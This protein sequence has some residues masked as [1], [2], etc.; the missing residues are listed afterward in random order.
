MWALKHSHKR[1]DQPHQML[2]KELRHGR[3]RRKRGNYC[4]NRGCIPNRVSI[5]SRTTVVEKR[6][7]IGDMEVDL[8]PGKDHQPGLMVITDRSTLRTSL[9]KIK[10]KA[11]RYIASSIIRKLKP[12]ESWIKTLTYDNY[13]AFAAHATVN[14]K[15][16]TKS[17]FTHPYTSEEKGTVENRIGVLRK[18][19]PKKTDFTLIT[20]RRVSQVEKM[21]NERPVRKFQYQ[22]PNAIFLQKSKVALIT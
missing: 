8:M 10:T 21:I 13:L 11:S 1:E 6:S 12:C 19:F 3:R 18:F 22:T 17:F 20:A 5:E 15:L 14:K 9:V 7:R 16:N 4:G 2:Y